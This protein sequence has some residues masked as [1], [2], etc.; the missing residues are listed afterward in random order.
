MKGKKMTP[1]WISLY[2]I[3]FGHNIPHIFLNKFR[4][5]LADGWGQNALPLANLLTQNLNVQ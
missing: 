5:S 4:S 2:S 1:F 3:F